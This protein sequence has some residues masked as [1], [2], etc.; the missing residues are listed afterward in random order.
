[1]ISFL[2][3]LRYALTPHDRRLLFADGILGFR[4][5]SGPAPR[6][7]G[8]NYRRKQSCRYGLMITTARRFI[9]GAFGNKTRIEVAKELALDSESLKAAIWK[10]RHDAKKKR[11]AA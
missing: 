4:P 9:A 11:R 1:M 3:P 7:G 10:L 5:G 6:G 8:H 2:N